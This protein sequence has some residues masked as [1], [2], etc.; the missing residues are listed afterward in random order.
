MLTTT[1]PT[2]FSLFCQQPFL[3]W[4]FANRFNIILA[5]FVASLSLQVQAVCFNRLPSSLIIRSTIDDAR[6]GINLH[7]SHLIFDCK[8]F[9]KKPL[10]YSI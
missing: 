9:L 10:V 4:A 5:I 2:Q 8:I 1:L 6:G 3:A 7:L